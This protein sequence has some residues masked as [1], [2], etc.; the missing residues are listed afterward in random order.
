M[1]KT[2]G[3]ERRKWDSLKS[4]G[5]VL[6]KGFVERRRSVERRRPAVTESSFEE[7]DRLMKSFKETNNGVKE[8]QATGLDRLIRP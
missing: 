2:R 6:P 8:T 4:W 5:I 7:F 1:Q 3:P